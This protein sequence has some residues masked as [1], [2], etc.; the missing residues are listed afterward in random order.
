[1][2]AWEVTTA[3]PGVL[4]DELGTRGVTVDMVHM[5]ERGG[6]GGLYVT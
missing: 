1:V 4:L 5:G 6:D 2:C 3:N